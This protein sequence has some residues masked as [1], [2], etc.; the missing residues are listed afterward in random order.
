MRLSNSMKQN[1]R[2]SLFAGGLVLLGACSQDNL[3]PQGNTNTGE[4]VRAE[5]GFLA[6]R[7]DDPEMKSRDTHKQYDDDYERFEWFN[8]GSKDER[9][10]VENSACNR[11][12]FFNED[13]S[14]YGA[15]RLGKPT[16]VTVASNIYVARQPLND[17][18]ELVPSYAMVVVNGDSVRLNQLEVDLQAAGV[19]AVNQ[20]LYYV[21]KKD[22]TKPESMAMC[23]VEGTKY[24]TMTS[25]VYRGGE[26]DNEDLIVALKQLNPEGPVFYE[27]EAEAVEPDNLVTFNVERILAKFTLIIKEGN[28]TFG[29]LYRPIIFEGPT[30]FKVR[31]NYAPAGGEVKDVMTGWKVNIANWGLNGL[32]KDTYLL[33]TLIPES[34]VAGDSYP[35]NISYLNYYA[36]WNSPVLQRAYW[37][38]DPNYDKGFYP[39]QYRQALDED[40]EFVMP[41]TKDNIYSAGYDG[42]LTREDYTLVYKPYSSF[43][44]R[45]DNKYSIENTFDPSVIANQDLNTSPWLR[46]G[47]HLIITAQLL[48]DEID[49][50]VL[51]NIDRGANMDESGFISGVSDK[52][53]SNGLWWAEKALLHQ[54][55][56]TLMTNLYFN[57]QGDNYKIRDVVNGG[58]VDFINPGN[59]NGDGM[60][61]NTNNP[62]DVIGPDGVR[63]Q[64]NSNTDLASFAETYFEFAPAFIK[65]GDGWITLKKKDGVKIYANYLN[66]TT[67][68]ITDA[69]I[70]SYIYRF[71]NLARHYAE[72]RMY[73]ALPIRHN[74]E[75]P[76]Y[77]TDPVTTVAPGDYGVVRNTW[78]RMTITSVLN[79]G[80]PVDDPDQP[81]IPNPQPNDKSLGVEVEII[82]WRT[83]DINVD[84]LH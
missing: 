17:N 18:E 46:S 40:G 72:G 48:F 11:V 6:F 47:T 54:A 41:A 53:F 52:Y 42:T 39:D 73:Y 32:E 66:N 28:Q 63:V 3:G 69:Q 55:V 38:L 9:A 23:E 50:E 84:Q 5:G 1:L 8:K 21:N 70:V 25:T 37:G 35:W 68:E 49:T 76:S 31:L 26:D 71:T 2:L 51:E 30:S 77:E 33:K 75:S 62:V 82:P 58:Y 61:L 64:Y 65:G 16:T 67:K 14:F 36:G 44:D 29:N 81:I 60:I 45:T 57:K 83:I 4:N 7:L 74:L 34:D 59:V 24:F 13:Y 78:Y 27:S 15:G 43:T 12:F 56:N 20:L 80:T 79:P 10:I 19:D 22:E